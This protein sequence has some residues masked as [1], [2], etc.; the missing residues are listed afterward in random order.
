MKT[1]LLLAFFQVVTAN[2]SSSINFDQ[3]FQYV[4][5][6]TK[7]KMEIFTTLEKVFKDKIIS[8]EE[9]KAMCKWVLPNF[10]KFTKST[11]IQSL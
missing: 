1:V 8:E 7:T 9:F 5:D 6:I 4:D 10:I 3:N 2:F 11:I